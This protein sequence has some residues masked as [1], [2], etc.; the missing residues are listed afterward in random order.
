MAGF[1]AGW[2]TD[3]PG[4]DTVLTPVHA[5][6]IPALNTLI[7]LSSGATITWAHWGLVKNNQSQL[8]SDWR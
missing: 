3:G 8:S 1:S 2:P 7:L 5:W 6:G 4:V